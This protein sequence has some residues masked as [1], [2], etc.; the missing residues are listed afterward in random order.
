[1][2]NAWK[3][4]V[5]SITLASTLFLPTVAL[6]ARKAL[7]VG[8]NDYASLPRLQTARKDAEAMSKLL[9][10]LGFS[11]TT[12]I[13]PAHAGFTQTWTRFIESITHDDIAAFFFAGHGVQVDAVN[14]LL[15]KDASGSE[16]GDEVL[17]KSSLNFHELMEGLEAKQPLASIYILDACRSNPFAG[18]PK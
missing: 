8:L 3:R 6:A 7:V 4:I 11:V 16:A 9:T 12:L 18:R 10:G 13:D 17:L 15:L 2:L 14:Y 5:I 1:M